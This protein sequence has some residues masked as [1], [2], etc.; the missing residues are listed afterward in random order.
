MQNGAIGIGGTALCKSS[1]RCS[2]NQRP[3]GWTEMSVCDF[4][5]HHPC[6]SKN[7]KELSCF[8]WLHLDFWVFTMLNSL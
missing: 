8:N 1:C 3:T 6:S 4:I 5:N 7:E 2:Q